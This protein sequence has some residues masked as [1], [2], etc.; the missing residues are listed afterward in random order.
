MLYLVLPG[1]LSVFLSLDLFFSMLNIL[2]LSVLVGNDFKRLTPFLVGFSDGGSVYD[3]AVG[4]DSFS[5]PGWLV[6]VGGYGNT[7]CDLY[8]LENSIAEYLNL[9]A[10][11]TINDEIED[12]YQQPGE[13]GLPGL[14]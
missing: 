10:K 12:E 11:V 9:G 5:Q 1:I 2:T 13:G 14:P 7:G 8:N 3:K 4:S 6:E